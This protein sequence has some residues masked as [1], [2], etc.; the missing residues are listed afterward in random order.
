MISSASLSPRASAH[1]KF[2][3]AYSPDSLASFRAWLGVIVFVLVL[4]LAH[5]VFALALLQL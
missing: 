5:Q 1:S 2:P 3:T 4:L